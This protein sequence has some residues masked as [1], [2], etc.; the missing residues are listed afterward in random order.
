MYVTGATGAGKSSQVP[1]LLLY[2]LKMVDFNSSGKVV[3]TQPRISPTV[4][5][6]N[7]IAEQMGVPI[8][9]YSKTLDT[10]IKTFMGYIQYKTMK[11]THLADKFNYYFKEMTDGSLVSELY[12]NPLLKK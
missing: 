4:S 1:K 12:I 7:E 10:N 8:N 11:N 5:N 3:S 2:G 6:A 9:S